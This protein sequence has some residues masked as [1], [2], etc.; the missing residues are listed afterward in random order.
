M[1]LVNILEGIHQVA[2]IPVEGSYSLEVDIQAVEV[3][4]QAVVVDKDF[5]LVLLDMVEV[6]ETYWIRRSNSLSV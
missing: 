3:D 2:D 5:S 1:G 6:A 4:I